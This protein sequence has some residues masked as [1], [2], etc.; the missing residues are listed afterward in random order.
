M[1]AKQDVEDNAATPY[2]NLFV[3]ILLDNLWGYIIRCA[4]ADCELFVR[5]EFATDAEVDY[6]YIP[7]V[8][9]ALEVL[10]RLNQ[11]IVG[12]NVP[13]NHLVHVAVVYC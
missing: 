11:N 7:V 3:V 4:N 8:H 6:L 9:F 5:I 13:M 10:G 1:S 2:I 12:F